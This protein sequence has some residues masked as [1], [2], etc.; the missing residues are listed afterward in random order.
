MLLISTYVA[1]S[2]IEGVGVFAATPIKK[3]S[4]IWQLNTDFDRLIPV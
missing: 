2:D 4:L 3:G 1:A